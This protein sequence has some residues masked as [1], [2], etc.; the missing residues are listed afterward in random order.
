MGDQEPKS[1]DITKIPRVSEIITRVILPPDYFSRA[2]RKTTIGDYVHQALEFKAKDILD[3]ESLDDQLI[4]YI[5]AYEQWEKD[6]KP[7]TIYSELRLVDSVFGFTGQIDRIAILEGKSAT[8]IIDFKTGNMSPWHIIQIAAYR[9]L[10]TSPSAF[11]LVDNDGFPINWK[12]E[13]PQG[14]YHLKQ[15]GPRGPLDEV[16]CANL[17]L[18]PNGKYT[19]LRYQLS[20]LIEARNI[21]MAALTIYNYR[22][23]L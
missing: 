12:D 6:F 21:F 8:F 20:E 3:E 19:F 9:E 18:K 11:M 10:Y 7:K 23:K 2:F 22:L 16:Y 14:R 15:I 1:L 4:P 5:Q 17:Y 13:A